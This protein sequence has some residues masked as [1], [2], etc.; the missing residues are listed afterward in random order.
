[1]C[2]QF[3]K[4][5]KLQTQKNVNQAFLIS[6]K[7]LAL[8]QRTWTAI[9]LIASINLQVLAIKLKLSGGIAPHAFRPLPDAALLCKFP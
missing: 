2:G 5:I 1:M 3:V 8:V 4:T 9:F 6:N 7:A